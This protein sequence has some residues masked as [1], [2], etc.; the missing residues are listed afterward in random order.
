MERYTSRSRQSDETAGFESGQYH[1]T[2]GFESGQYHKAAGPETGQPEKLGKIRHTWAWVYGILLTAYTAFTMLNVF[3]IPHD[4]VKMDQSAMAEVYRT[5]TADEVTSSGGNIAETESVRGM[6]SSETGATEAVTEPTV[7]A[8]ENGYIYQDSTMTITLTERY[9]YSTMVYVADIQLSGIA[10]LRSGLAED[11]FGR[12]LTE[13][14]SDIADRVGAILAINGD[15]YGFRDTGYVIRNGILYRDRKKSDDAEDLV[16]YEDGSMQIIREGD[17]T[18]E[19]LLANGALQVYSFG[20]GL[21]ENGE[22]T[23]DSSSEVS[24]SMSSNPRTAI[25]M[26]EPLHYVMVVSDGRTSESEGLSLLQ[27]ATIMQDLGCEQAYNLD[28]GGSTT[29]YFNGQVINNPTTSGKKTKE[30]SVSDIV[31]IGY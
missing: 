30:R 15:F 20:P 6:I 23:V 22:I 2:A 27:L 9:V 3:V 18:A 5:D 25:G 19:E 31:Y 13:K 24:K 12:N 1:K 16:I 8:T 29:M 7:T 26:I 14:T 21:V 4:T 28:G 10:T 11:S 17:V